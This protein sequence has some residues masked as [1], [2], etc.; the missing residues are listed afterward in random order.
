MGG[1][2]T[3]HV[4]DNVVMG[5]FFRKPLGLFAA[6]VVV[7]LVLIVAAMT[8]F[9][10][11]S[12]HPDYAPKPLTPA[13]F[14]QAS[15]RIGRSICLQLKPIVNKKPHTLREVASTIGRISTVFDRFTRDFDGLVPPPA[16]ARLI[17]RLRRNLGVLDG[18]VHRAAHLAETHQWRRLV[19]FVRSPYFKKIGKRFGPAKKGKLRCG[20]AS[21]T[22]A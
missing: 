14:R 13:Q 2:G 18:A 10:G 16:A 11:T 17:L 7:G 6:I 20:R 12:G 5:S 9:G 15:E 4:P 21:L 22:T 19:L 3:G 1:S 8:A